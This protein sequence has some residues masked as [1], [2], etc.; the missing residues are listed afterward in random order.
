MDIKTVEAVLKENPFFKGMS[1]QHIATLA[2]CAS[3]VRFRPGDVIFSQQDEADHFF[4]IQEGMVAVDIESAERGRITIQSV[5]EGMILGWSW[6]FP[7]YIWHFD[8]RCTA[9]VKAISFDARCIRGKCEEDNALGYQLMKRF[10]AIMI[11][12]LQATRLQL[13][14]FYGT[15]KTES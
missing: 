1:P 3:N 10:S 11:E 6:L 4:L 12:R 14:D 8:A 9:P 15:A 2:G 13:L 7:P 5:E